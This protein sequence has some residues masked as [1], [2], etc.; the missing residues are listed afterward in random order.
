M[1]RPTSDINHMKNILIIGTSYPYRGGLAAF[2]ERLACEIQSAGDRVRIE[3]FTL[4]YPGILFP[5]KTQ[6]A[7]WG[8][9]ENLDIRRSVNSV[10]PVNWLRT[11]IR[12][13][14]QKPDLVIFKYWMPFMA[15]S[16]GTIAHTI[17]K[18]GHSRIITILDNIIPHEQRPGDRW[19]TKYFVKQVDGFIAMSKAVLSD[20]DKFDTG[21]PRI[22]SPHPVFDNFGTAISREK[23]ISNLGLDPSYRYVLFFGLVR[24]YKGLDIIINAFANNS[25]REMGIKLLVAGEF[26]T[27]REPYDMLIEKHGLKNDIIIHPEFVADSDVANWF[28]AS[29]I[30]A[31]PYKTATQSGVTQI[32][33]HFNKPML[34]SDVG[35][36]PEIIPHGR[37]GYVV[38]PEPETVAQALIDFF[39]NDRYDEFSHGIKKEKGKYSW[40]TMVK[41]LY[42]LSEQIKER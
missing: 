2:N 8:A 28:C 42:L 16:F 22:Y 5:G 23:A 39:S 34:V 30:I 20:L 15:P 9:P 3:T 7:T 35:G 29:D 11:G 19:M 10:W 41:N 37:G 25:L 4:Q 12:L 40:E 17:R 36:L 33:Y 26:Y 38:K 6:F 18:N 21:K 13:K 27:G 1:Q 14:R 31:Q 24:D 32:G